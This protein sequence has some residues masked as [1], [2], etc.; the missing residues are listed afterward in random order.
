[1]LKNRPICFISYVGR[2]LFFLL[3]SILIEQSEYVLTIRILFCLSSLNVSKS[4]KQRESFCIIQP[5]IK[6]N[7]E[8]IISFA[9][10]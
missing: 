3:A 7:L 8:F 5:L 1:M 4:L 10:V 6:I 2:E 9:L